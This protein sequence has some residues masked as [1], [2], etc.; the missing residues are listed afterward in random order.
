MIP[1]DYVNYRSSGEFNKE[2]IPK[3]LLNSHNTKA[4]VYGKITVLEGSLKFY[5]L[6]SDN[7]DIEKIL[8]INKSES[9]VSPPQYWHK[10]ELL[11]EDTRFKIDFYAHKDSEIAQK[12]L[13]ERDLF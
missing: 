11:R 6:T 9:A 12:N 4:G 13:S 1:N 5:G 3:L 10:V 8:I 2:T 7:G